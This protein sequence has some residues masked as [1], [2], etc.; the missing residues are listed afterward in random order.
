MHR[1]GDSTLKLPWR[2]SCNIL[3]LLSKTRTRRDFLQLGKQNCK[4]LKVGSGG[5]RIHHQIWGGG[6]PGARGS[7]RNCHPRPARSP[8][9]LVRT[10]GKNS[11]VPAAS[12]NRTHRSWPNSRP[13]ALRSWHPRT[14]RHRELRVR[15]VSESLHARNHQLR[16]IPPRFLLLCSSAS[17]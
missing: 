11:Q 13:P 17:L 15:L 16:A 3:F 8:S 12:P 7:C 14:K 9:S 1:S 6:N 2:L 4:K 5:R 10:R